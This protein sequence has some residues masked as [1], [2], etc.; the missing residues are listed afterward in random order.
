MFTDMSVSQ[1]LN[2]KFNDQIKENNVDLGV[3]F[4][5]QV[6]QVSASDELKN[7]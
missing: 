2:N 4:T 7:C 1:D 3:N 5:I 6:L